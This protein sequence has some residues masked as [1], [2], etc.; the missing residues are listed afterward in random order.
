MGILCV[1]GKLVRTLDTHDDNNNIMMLYFIYTE[2]A[3]NHQ[4]NKIKHI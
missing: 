4:T 1:H 2:Y 3:F